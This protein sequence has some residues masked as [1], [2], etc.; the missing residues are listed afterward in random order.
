MA[1]LRPPRLLSAHNLE[2]RFSMILI[3]RTTPDVGDGARCFAALDRL[4]RTDA[5]R[6]QCGWAGF[7]TTFG[8]LSSN[9]GK[10][11]GWVG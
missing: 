1:F 9:R 11:F 4:I 3:R 10:A 6:P 5:R 7:P 8:R 2:F